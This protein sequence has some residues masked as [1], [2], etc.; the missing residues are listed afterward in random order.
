MLMAFA[1]AKG[2]AKT[3]IFEMELKDPS[4]HSITGKKDLYYLLRFY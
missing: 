3:K 2:H 4:F 1:L